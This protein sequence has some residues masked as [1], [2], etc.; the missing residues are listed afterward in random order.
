MED[1]FILEDYLPLNTNAINGYKSESEVEYINYLWGAYRA[2]FEAETY[3]FS[4]LAYHMLF[5]AFCYFNIWQ[6]KN[7]QPAEFKK[8]M[9]GKYKPVFL[10]PDSTPFQFSIEKEKKVFQLLNLSKT[11]KGLISKCKS[12]VEFRD[13]LAHCNGQIHAAN[14]AGHYERIGGYTPLIQ[15]IQ[16]DSKELIN[17]A[18]CAF[19]KD[20]LNGWNNLEEAKLD[21]EE[22]FIKKLYISKEDLRFCIYNKK[23]AIVAE[24]EDYLKAEYLN[25]EN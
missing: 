3:Q 11:N 2:N 10:E 21:F 12:L 15:P 1:G 13:E 14:E 23:N 7:L 22:V 16:E 20:Y 17:S 6:S 18:Y 9:A 5:M 25:E 4:I 24:L 8:I 19:I